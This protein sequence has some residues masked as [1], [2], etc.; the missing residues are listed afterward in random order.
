MSPMSVQV[1]H[2]RP[3]FYDGALPQ[4]RRSSG[5][6]Y[7]HQM[8]AAQLETWNGQDSL[9]RIGGG[10]IDRAQGLSVCM[11]VERSLSIQVRGDALNESFV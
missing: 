9:V 7:R 10:Y 1:A 8:G 5:F 11:Y 6:V 4:D 3:I 2:L